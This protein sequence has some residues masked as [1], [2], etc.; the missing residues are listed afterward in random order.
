MLNF[1]DF[2]QFTSLSEAKRFVEKE[3]A[4]ANELEKVLLKCWV[5]V[6]ECQHKALGKCMTYADFKSEVKLYELLAMVKGYLIDVSDVGGIDRA[7][8]LLANKGVSNND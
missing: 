1:F 6:C 3:Y 5:Y 8:S 7:I 2:T 4:R